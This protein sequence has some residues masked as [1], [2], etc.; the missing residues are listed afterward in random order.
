MLLLS[1]FKLG[2]F[3]L[4]I[5]LK[6]MSSL[7]TDIIHHMYQSTG[8]QNLKSP[9][10]QPFTLPRDILLWM[11]TTVSGYNSAASSKWEKHKTIQCYWIIY[12]NLA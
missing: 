1:G 6:N 7:V 4:F 3:A 11:H 12:E 8:F 5:Y 2:K 10:Q 9:W